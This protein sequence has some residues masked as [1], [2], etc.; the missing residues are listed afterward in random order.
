MG[1]TFEFDLTPDSFL[2]RFQEL[3]LAQKGSI[4]KLRNAV[5]IDDGESKVQ[6]LDFEYAGT[7]YTLGTPSGGGH[8]ETGRNQTVLLWLNPPADLPDMVLQPRGEWFKKISSVFI[9]DNLDYESMGMHEQLIPTRESADLGRKYR[10][11]LAADQ[12]DFCFDEASAT[13]IVP[14]DRPWVIEKAGPVLAVYSTSWVWPNRSYDREYAKARR[15][16]QAFH[17]LIRP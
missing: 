4:V 11:W 1:G 9:G 13:K 17:R 15:I 14:G 3:P 16:L 7:S 5:L 6:L 8:I 12:A 10:L 2:A